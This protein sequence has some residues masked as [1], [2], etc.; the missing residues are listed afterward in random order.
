[1]MYDWHDGWGWSWGTWVMMIIAMALFWGLIA[2]AAV[3]L[4]Q[5]WS[6]GPPAPPHLPTGKQAPAGEPGPGGEPA[7]GI[8]DAALRILEERFA[9]GEMDPEEFTERREL[10]RGR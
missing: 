8:P 2:T 4:W 3:L 5:R 10:L 1:M 9:R 7:P 6:P